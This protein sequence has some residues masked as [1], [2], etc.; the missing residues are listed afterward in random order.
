V[1]TV[2]FPGARIEAPTRF[3]LDRV[4]QSWGRDIEALLGRVLWA[5]RS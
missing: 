1:I 5:V 3:A 2:S 4:R